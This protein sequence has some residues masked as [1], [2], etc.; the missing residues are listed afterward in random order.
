MLNYQRVITINHH[1]WEWNFAGKSPCGA[2]SKTAHLSGW[3]LSPSAR[4][5]CSHPKLFLMVPSNVPEKFRYPNKS[6]RYSEIVEIAVI[7]CYKL[8][9]ID[10]SKA[11][12]HHP[13]SNIRPCIYSVATYWPRHP[14]PAAVPQL[15]SLPH[16]MEMTSLPSGYW[17]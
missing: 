6:M 3:F 5:G 2:S 11:I 12:Q 15:M 1:K 9:T 17:T 14:S 7:K 4:R 16:V 13:T 8:I 10:L